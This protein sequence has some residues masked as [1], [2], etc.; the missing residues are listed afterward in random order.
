MSYKSIVTFVASETGMS[1]LLDHAV[2]LA[3]RF[4]AHLEVCCM[5]VD[6]TQSIGFYAGAPAIIYQDA[7]EN[8][9]AS[10]DA[11]QKQARSL[12]DGQSLRWG[13]DSAVV[14]LGGISSYVGLKARFAD[15][16]V[17]PQ[18]YGP[19]RGPQDEVVIESALFEGDAPVLV[20]PE[21][22]GGLPSFSR[23]VLGWNQSDEAIHAARAALPLLQNADSVNLV[24]I[25]PPTHGPER[26]D[27][28]GLLAQMLARHGVSADVSVLARTLPRTSDILKRHVKDKDADLLVMGAY[29]RSRL[30]EAILGGATRDM[31]QAADCAVLMKH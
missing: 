13:T 11:L 19:S 23:I 6:S 29:G 3:Q 31:L 2:A 25:D 12:L 18:P 16:V 9:K 28:G 24:V 10:A 1:P 4:D 14:S 7:L 15:L 26:S 17:L 20:L 21:A 30:R 5:G 8:A 22:K 27:P